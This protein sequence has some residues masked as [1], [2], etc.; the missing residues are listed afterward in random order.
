MFS[1]PDKPV[2]KNT[3]APGDPGS[4]TSPF[5]TP[6]KPK[7]ETPPERPKVPAASIP[8]QTHIPS[9]KPPLPAVRPEK[10]AAPA[11]APRPQP[12]PVRSEPVKPEPH[13][14][15]AEAIASSGLFQ[16]LGAGPQRKGAS[17][18][19]AIVVGV[20][21]LA[22]LGYVFLRPKKPAP[23]EET[24]NAPES[25]TQAVVQAPQEEIMSPPPV[26]PKPVERKVEPK[27]KRVEPGPTAV[28]PIMPQVGPSG[29]P[30]LTPGNGSNASQ[31]AI[32][33]PAQAAPP[34]VKTEEA[35]PP[36]TN[37]PETARGSAASVETAAYPPAAQQLG[38]EGLITVNA[39]IDE[40]GNVIDTG[41]LKGIKDDKGLGQAAETAVKKWKFEP[42]R[43]NGVAVKVWKPIVIAFKSGKEETDTE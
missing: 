11:P 7:P 3:L 12:E 38:I 36:A 27:P 2:T 26:E 37:P 21:A 28:E 30:P 22:V 23:I 33:N 1:I 35:A 19:V 25:A 40:K 15:E 16:D 5:F 18:V 29:A 32:S 9:P 31:G 20:A 24:L 39:L 41:I 13:R 6:E 17:P 14:A 42:A 8:H 10:K 4:D 34:P 43:K